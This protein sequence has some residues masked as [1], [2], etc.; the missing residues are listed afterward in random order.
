MDDKAAT[1]SS[2][3]T[4]CRYRY[5]PIAIQDGESQ[6]YLPSLRLMHLYLR[7]FDICLVIETDLQ[8]YNQRTSKHHTAEVVR[9]LQRVLLKQMSS[10]A[11]SLC[12]SV[13]LI[14]YLQVSSA[15]AW[16]ERI[17]HAIDSLSG[18]VLVGVINAD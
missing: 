4:I 6:F 5:S 13:S 11:L 8:L 14:S 3:C 7:N 18:R 9:V 17:R 12:V 10:P 1:E 2:S 15:V 16:R